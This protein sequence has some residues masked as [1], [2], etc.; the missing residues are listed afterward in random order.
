MYTIDPTKLLQDYEREG[1]VR[2]PPP[3]TPR[4][5]ATSR[6]NSTRPLQKQF[7]IRQ[8]EQI[9]AAGVRATPVG[10]RII[11]HHAAGGRMNSEQQGAEV[12]A[13]KR[14]RDPGGSSVQSHGMRRDGVCGG[15]HLIPQ[16]EIGAAK[17]P[18]LSKIVRAFGPRSSRLME[19]LR[20]DAGFVRDL[21]S[22]LLPRV[23]SWSYSG[24]P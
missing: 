16:C 8:P 24:H 12:C 15:E 22:N 20:F 9:A 21:I 4:P 19:R 6:A 17:G 18:G 14:A 1:V 7:P 11:D 2:V 23:R 10:E 3:L 5:R 13:V